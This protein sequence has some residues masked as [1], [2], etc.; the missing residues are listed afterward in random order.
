MKQKCKYCS[1]ADAYDIMHSVTKNNKNK[2]TREKV[3][4]DY[5]TMYPRNGT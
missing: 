1:F 2:T 4:H 5:K 3:N